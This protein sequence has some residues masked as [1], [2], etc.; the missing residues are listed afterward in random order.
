MTSSSNL[1]I[2]KQQTGPSTTQMESS[3]TVAVDR[4]EW[5]RVQRELVELRQS[6]NRSRCSSASAITI[7][8]LGGM[9]SDGTPNGTKI[10]SA[11]SGIPLPHGGVWK[12]FDDSRSMRRFIA[13]V[14]EV[15]RAAGLE[16][17]AIFHYLTTRCIQPLLA[18]ELLKNCPSVTGALIDYHA[19]CV[20]AEKFLNERFEITNRS[21][22][23]LNKFKTRSWCRDCS[24]FGEYVERFEYMVQ[25]AYLLGQEL[26]EDTKR[27]WFLDGFPGA[28][29]ERV[30]NRYDTDMSVTSLVSKMTH[31]LQITGENPFSLR[32]RAQVRVVGGDVSSKFRCFGCGQEGHMRRDCPAPKRIPGRIPE[33]SRN[34]VEP[35]ECNPEVSWNAVL[36]L[37]R[38][39]VRGKNA[40]SK[41][42]VGNH[43]DVKLAVEFD[44]LLDSGA[45]KTVASKNFANVLLREGLI[46]QADVRPGKAPELQFGNKAIVK[47]LGTVPVIIEG[48]K[49][50]LIVVESLCSDLIIGLDQMAENPVVLQKLVAL[51][52]NCSL[53]EAARICAVDTTPAVQKDIGDKQ[54]VPEGVAEG[55]VNQDSWKEDLVVEDQEVESGQTPVHCDWP[56]VE[57]PWREGAVDALLCNSKQAR[58]EASQMHRRMTVKSPELLVAYQEVLTSWVSEGWLEEVDQSKVRYCLRHFPV[59]KDVNGTTAMSR[60]RVV[61]DGSGLTPLFNAK[62]CS[63]TDMVKTSV[64]WRTCDVFTCLDISQAY[65]RIGISERDSYFLCIAWK[66]LFYRF[67]SLPMGIS[68]SAQ[69]LQEAVDA[70]VTEWE[71]GFVGENIDVRVVP[72]MDDLIQ[73]IWMGTAQI[74]Y[75]AVEGEAGDSLQKFLRLKGMQVS[76]DKT[77]NTNSASGKLLGVLYTAGRISANSRLSKLALEEVSRQLQG[78]ITRKKAVGWISSLFDPLGLIAEVG[79]RGRLLSSQFSGLAWNKTLPEKFSSDIFKWI[80][81]MKE[82]LRVSIPRKVS[83]SELWVFTDASAVGVAV[84]VV[85]RGGDGSWSRLYA[86]AKVHKKYQRAW[87]G[88]SSKIELLALQT[89]VQVIAYLQKILK[90][91]PNLGN[92][93]WTVGTDSEVNLNR[94]HDFTFD[95]IS[96]KWE[97]QVAREVNDSLAKIG[98]TVYHV[99]GLLNP[100]DPLSRGIWS[101]TSVS[102]DQA[103]DWY[104]EDRA[105]QPVKCTAKMKDESDVDISELPEEVEEINTIHSAGVIVSLDE[106]YRTERTGDISRAEWMLAYQEQDERIKLLINEGKVFKHNGVWVLKHV[107]D[108]DGMIVHPVIVPQELTRNAL[109]S[110]HDREGHFGYRKC[111]SKARDMFHWRRMAVQLKKHCLTCEIC[112]RVK[113]NRVWSTEPGT[114]HVEGRCWS[115]VGVDIVK[116]TPLPVITLTDMYTRYMFTQGL[117]RETTQEI[118]SFL[119]KVFALEG[120]PAILISDNAAVFTCPEFRAFLEL[121]AV[122]GKQIPRYSPWYGGFYEAGHKA[123]VKTLI[124]ILNGP[125]KNRNWQ[126]DLMVATMHY[127]SRCYEFTGANSLSPQEVFRGRQRSSPWTRKIMEVED[128]TPTE[129]Q[130]IDAV[131]SICTNRSFIIKVFDD[132]WKRM[133]TAAIKEIGKRHKNAEQLRLG[134]RVYVW[135]P[136]LTR[137]KLDPQWE[138]PFEITEKL[139]PVMWL[140]NGK[141]EHVY[142]L[143]KAAGVR[144]DAPVVVDSGHN[145]RMS[146]ATYADVGKRLRLE[147]MLALEPTGELL[148]L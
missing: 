25:E 148:W 134:D 21:D 55:Q 131:E 81:E 49:V 50:E 73:M 146:E 44:A 132:T 113:G 1:G 112:E 37:A 144:E 47:P 101:G 19:G 56:L 79:M 78:G 28:F 40:M 139:S 130:M 67:K 83:C 12:N 53:E 129:M 82:A 31:W 57:L 107:Q 104:S 109:V 70:F 62:V 108:P 42:V 8:S 85:G 48:N 54:T 98:A 76:V 7:G 72:Y 89:G 43:R 75:A 87:I 24:T 116:G 122:H 136:R 30:V 17:R 26:N 4:A 58:I 143:K 45:T 6:G 120:A 145:E 110:V 90:D 63:H 93:R 114:L 135:V 141:V 106:R 33:T 137:G 14:V 99:P 125:D 68:P 65:M 51:A 80:K 74:D 100:A 69:A 117:K 9:V 64:L 36:Q 147:V 41:V 61:V 103:V 10:L 126:K 77:W 119:D 38:T 84:I 105:V 88:T 127:N 102:Y 2:E 97:R 11:I 66:N 34:D 133:R 121:W 22:R 86:R 71:M 46:V 32:T 115:V 123:L 94:F 16:F 15:S 95:S 92:I 138:G 140:V 13:S 60:C 23:F 91:V 142:N 35:R 124:A 118:I 29:A 20:E 96:D 5:D 52:R 27:Y 111:L 128:P 39:D 59:A 3:D 18:G